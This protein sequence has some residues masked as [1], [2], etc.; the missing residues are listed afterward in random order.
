[1]IVRISF[2]LSTVVGC[3][4]AH[5][6]PRDVKV[7]MWLR[8]DA[9][10][11]TLAVRVPL[12]AMRDVVFPEVAGG[13]LDVEKLEPRLPEVATT[14]VSNAILLREADRELGRPQVVGT[15]LALQSDRT[16]E[17]FGRGAKTAFGS[18]AR[19]VWDQLWIDVL[20]EIPVRV[21]SSRFAVRPGITALGS[22]VW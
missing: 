4:L 13:Y 8:A 12:K 22:A 2:L 16:F 5:E 10:K 21:E 7:E 17:A 15:R 3:A 18:E 9:G 19:V 14:W 11:M 6:I 20:M 1:M